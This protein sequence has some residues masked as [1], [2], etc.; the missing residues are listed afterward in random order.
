[1]GADEVLEQL[2]DGNRRFVRGEAC[3]EYSPSRREAVAESPDPS[4]VIVGCSDSRVPVEAV[5]DMGIGDAWVV[6]SAGH[7]L[8]EAGLASVR[9]GVETWGIPLV[10][11]VGHEDCQAVRAAVEGFNPAWLRPITDY[12]EAE[13]LLP[14]SSPADES[15]ALIRAVDAHVAA[16]VAALTTHLKG[17]ALPDAAMPV[18]VGCTYH[19]ATGEVRWLT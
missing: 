5:F 17:L 3:T 9:F 14:D 2:R 13:P 19:P 1:M 7:V 10:L 4:V 11:V 8:S 12:I 15:D 6:R 16:S 18:V